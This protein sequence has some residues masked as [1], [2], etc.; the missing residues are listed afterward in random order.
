VETTRSPKGR[1][2][3]IQA[4]F[5]EEEGMI[6]VTEDGRYVGIS[7]LE[8]IIDRISRLEKKEGDGRK[9]DSPVWTEVLGRKSKKK[10]AREPLRTRLAGVI[11]PQRKEKEDEGIMEEREPEDRNMKRRVAS[12][13]TRIDWTRVIHSA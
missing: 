13:W 11:P 4:G 5:Q 2:I 7:K 9:E 12:V 8:E 3:G 1:E 10:A 6:T